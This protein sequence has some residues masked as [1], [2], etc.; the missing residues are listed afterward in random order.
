M[1]KRKEEGKKGKAKDGHHQIHIFHSAKEGEERE[2]R[3]REQKSGA[4]GYK[5]SLN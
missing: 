1:K 4:D 3:R 5:F 2:G